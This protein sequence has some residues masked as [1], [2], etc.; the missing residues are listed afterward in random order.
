MALW[1]DEGSDPMTGSE[2]SDI[3]AITALKESAALE[4]KEKGNQYVKMGKKHYT[5][6]ID[7]Y[8]RAINQKALNDSENSIIFSNRAHV[9]L[10]LG[11]YRRALVDAE[12][13]I[14]LCSTNIKAFYRA[15]KAA[16]SLNLLTEAASFC[17]SG[18]KHFPSN[19]ELKKLVKQIDLRRTEIE[20]H[21]A[22]VL[23][24]VT[25]AKD[26][27]S[28]IENRGL[29]L[30]KAMYQEL[31]GIRK[32]TLDKNNILHWPVLLLYA[33]VMS[34]DFIEDFCET[35]MFSSHLDQMYSEACLPLPWDKESAYTR[36]AVELYYEAH[37][38]IILSKREVLQHLLQGTAGSLSES[39]CDEGKDAD[40]SSTRAVSSGKGSGKWVKV[41]EERTLL[42]IMRQPDC[43]I[44][45]IPVF[46]VVS[47]RSPFY[48]EFRAGKWAP[49]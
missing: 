7:C 26:L 38:G 10:L 17:Q 15:A 33:E 19:E 39:I 16:F 40:D 36:E 25:A 46:Y 48:K 1:M 47:N 34:S 24:A 9:N 2:Q 3:D 42:D 14:K 43:I 28:A 23:R 30:G 44:P 41:N 11:N 22:Q 20:N 37:A 6:A 21:D 35:D 27:A 29:K 12:E 18:L 49:P 32:P 31:T 13:A 45:G 4:L 5:D 8:T